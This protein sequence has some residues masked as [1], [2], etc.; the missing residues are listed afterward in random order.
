MDTERLSMVLVLF[1][2]LLFVVGGVWCAM[3][4]VWCM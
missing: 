2:F 3:F 1:L 4:G